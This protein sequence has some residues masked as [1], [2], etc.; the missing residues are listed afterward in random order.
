MMLFICMSTILIILILG[1]EYD[2]PLGPGYHNPP[3]LE[4]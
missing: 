1:L 2:H 4:D 3:P